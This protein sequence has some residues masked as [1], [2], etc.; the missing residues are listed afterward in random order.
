MDIN[1]H[2]HIKHAAKDHDTHIDTLLTPCCKMVLVSV[3]E[4]AGPRSKNTNTN[5]I[6]GQFCHNGWLTSIQR[7]NLE[8]PKES[9][10]DVLSL[11]MFKNYDVAI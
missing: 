8:H 9:T 2:T 3:V 5:I 11:K 1:T 6:R 4:A 10:L 7:W